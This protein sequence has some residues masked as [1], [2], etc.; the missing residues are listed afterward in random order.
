MITKICE[1]CG[2]EFIAKNRT[3]R[4]CNGDH[5]TKCVICGKDFVYNPKWKYVPQTC[6][7][8]CKQVL[9]VQLLQ[10]K[11]GV[12]NVSQLDEV[13]KKKS[14]VNASK[15]SQDKM[16]QTCLKNMGMNVLIKILLFERRFQKH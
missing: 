9:R 7:Q 3:Q 6:S 13:K 5:Y 2:K 8:A 1:A 12:D 10:E 14:I 16:K 4:F 15:E 11:Y